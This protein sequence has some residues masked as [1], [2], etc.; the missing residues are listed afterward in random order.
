MQFPQ[1]HCLCSDKKPENQ[2]DLNVYFTYCLSA[3]Q[4]HIGA[5]IDKGNQYD[6]H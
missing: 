3:V 2:F 4:H 6:E 1:T 5:G